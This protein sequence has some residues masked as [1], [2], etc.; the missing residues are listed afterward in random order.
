MI[1]RDSEKAFLIALLLNY[2]EYLALGRPWLDL[3]EVK[4]NAKVI[5]NKG[6]EEYLTEL[7]TDVRG[8]HVNVVPEF[9]FFGPGFPISHF[10][11]YHLCS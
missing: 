10:V 7:R 1:G 11:V 5:L 3:S 6:S 4:I 9:S 2:C 8:I